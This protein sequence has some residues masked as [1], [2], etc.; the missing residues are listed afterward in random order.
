MDVKAGLNPAT[1]AFGSAK[2]TLVTLMVGFPI[3]TPC[4]QSW[5]YLAVLFWIMES[6]RVIEKPKRRGRFSQQ[7]DVWD[8]VHQERFNRWL[9]GDPIEAIAE[10]HYVDVSQCSSVGCESYGSWPP[11]RCRIRRGTG[12]QVMASLRNLA[13]LSEPA[14][15]G[16]SR[17]DV[18]DSLTRA[19]DEFVCFDKNA[20][21]GLNSLVFQN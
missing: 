10:K 18:S 1:V 3:T 7:R 5:A 14:V 21:F 9:E 16:L 15:T 11:P 12:A 4:D 8:L 17:G 2:A 19:R 20:C 13:R 6:V